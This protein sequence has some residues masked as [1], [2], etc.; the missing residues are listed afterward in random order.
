MSVHLMMAP[1][2]LF[3]Q[4]STRTKKKCEQTNGFDVCCVVV[5]LLLQNI[6]VVFD[7][8]HNRINDDSHGDK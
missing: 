2:K 8:L 5:L 6:C 3:P 7:A 4:P 1:Y